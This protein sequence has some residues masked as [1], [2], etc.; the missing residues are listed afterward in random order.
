MGIQAYMQAIPIAFSAGSTLYLTALMLGIGVHMGWI[1]DPSPTAQ[2]FGLWWVILLT[3]IFYAV[4]NVMAVIPLPGI[5]T[6]IHVVW[7]I[8]HII[9]API[10]GAF[11]GIATSGVDAESALPVAVVSAAVTFVPHITKS[12]GRRT[13]DLMPVPGKHLAFNMVKDLLVAGFLGLYLVALQHPLLMGSMSIFTIGLVVFLTYQLAATTR[14][15]IFQMSAILTRF[16]TLFVKSKTSD[17]VPS[18]HLALLGHQEPEIATRGLAQAGISGGNWRTGYILLLNQQLVFTYSTMFSGDKLW[19]ININQVEIAY[20]YRRALVDVLEIHFADSKNKKRFARFVFLK[21]KEHLI[22]QIANRLEAK[23][24][25]TGIVAFSDKVSESGRKVVA[26]TASGIT[27]GI[28][29][30][31]KAATKSKQVAETTTSHISQGVAI[32]MD[33]GRDVANNAAA[34]IKQGMVVGLDKGKPVAD[35]ALA[36]GMEK[37]KTVTAMIKSWFEKK[38]K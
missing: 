20:L 8:I 11:L 31:K 13:L 18:P 2:F 9:V 14:W 6:L 17:I 19:Q 28:E 25:T 12:A 35:A 36:K 15:I 4:E 29:E 5:G 16:T 21:D 1:Q 23:V 37:G 7:D 38:I 22:Q 10:I 32:G 30:S 33:K 24:T 26:S 3:F 34:N 27:T